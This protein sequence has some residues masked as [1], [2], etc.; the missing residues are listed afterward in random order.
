MLK[1]SPFLQGD[2]EVFDSITDGALK[3]RVKNHLIAREHDFFAVVQPGFERVTS[4][5]FSGMGLSVK[6]IYIEGGVEFTGKPGSCY[7]AS[8]LSRTAGRI[9]MRVAE[10]R[11]SGYFELERSIRSFPWELYISPG[12]EIIFSASA[13]KS[14]IYH[15][16]KLEE[17]FNAGIKERLVSKGIENRNNETSCSQTVFLRNNRDVCTVSLDASG[18]SLYKR[19]R[20]KNIS[21]APLRETTAALILLEAGIGRYGLIIDP[22]CG[23]G[24]FSLETASIFTKTPPNCEREFT[25]MHWPCFR[26]GTFGFIRKSAMKEVIPQENIEQKIITSDID[27]EA[28]KIAESN[29]P[30]QFNKIIEPAVSDFFA[31]P[32][33]IAKDKKSL[34]VLNPP[35]GRRIGEPGDKSLYREIG[36]KIRKDF[37]NCGYAVIVPGH[38]KEN[39]MGLDY[40]RKIPFMNGGIKAAVVFR[41][42][43]V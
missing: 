43:K 21:R 23:S 14:M 10:F 15:T 33:N 11:S 38:E 26:M 3:R 34:I 17:I 42:A 7:T 18:E 35:Y 27:P 4:A 9:M 20:G 29:I 24:T 12:T 41:D 16:G 25:F 2:E 28:V 30:E 5:E 6:D 8:L 13:A 19:G 22:M 31:L 32:G 40:D 1:P 36:K 37:G 39:V